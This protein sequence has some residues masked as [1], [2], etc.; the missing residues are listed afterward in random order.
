M[1]R[2]SLLALPAILA[3]ARALPAK[4]A[5]EATPGSQGLVLVLNSRDATIGVVDP[6]SMSEVRRIPMLREPHHLAYTPTGEV[7]VADSGANEVFYLDPVTAEI[8]RREAIG[9]PYHL[10]FGPG[11]RDF[12]ICSLRRGQVDLFRWNGRSPELAYRVRTPPKPS[13]LAYSPDGTRVYV[14]LQG[15]GEL[16][17]ISLATGEAEWTIPIG[18]E[19]AGIM[20]HADRLLISIMGSDHV[21]V[22]NPATREVEGRVPVGRGAHTVWLAPGG[23]A[24]YATSRVESR[25]TV[26][27]P[28]SFTPVQVLPV[29]GGPDCMTFDHEGRMWVTQRWVGRISRVDPETGLIETVRVGRSPHGILFLPPRSA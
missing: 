26:L 21:A 1:N 5:V 23:G 27:D 16:T 25:I 11:G 29:T 10:G 4:A 18:P 12:V 17:A 7:M 3:G 19:P 22:V 2:R 9:N 6:V 24:I 15:S 8:R 20:W 13:H 28:R 14:T